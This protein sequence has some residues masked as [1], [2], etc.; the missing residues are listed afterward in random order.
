MWTNA[1]LAVFFY[2]FGF[3]PVC[4]KSEVGELYRL[5]DEDEKLVGIMEAFLSGHFLG[6]A[7]KGLVVLTHR[8]IFFFRK[9]VIGRDTFFETDLPCITY[10]C[11][12]EVAASLEIVSN[13]EKVVFTQCNRRLAHKLAILLTN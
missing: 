4:T 7:G 1:R 10:V 13:K 8:R 5:L 12:D 11:F 9:S 6:I 3:E 2:D